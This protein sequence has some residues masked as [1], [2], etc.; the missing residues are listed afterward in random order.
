[1]SG[2]GQVSFYTL[3]FSHTGGGTGGWDDAP[4]NE[5]PVD[6]DAGEN[7]SDN[8]DYG[9]PPEPPDYDSPAWWDLFG[10]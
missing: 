6:S 8:F 4:V 9:N 7:P 3:D 2:E 5:K 10:F 1:L